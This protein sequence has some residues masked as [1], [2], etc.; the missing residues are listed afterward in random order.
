MKHAFTRDN[1]LPK[2][3]G[4]FN[5]M[6][7]RAFVR[8]AMGAMVLGHLVGHGESDRHLSDRPNFLWMTCEDMSPLFAA[9]SL[10]I[11]TQ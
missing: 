11:T 4:V 6:K 9:I 10:S 8:S 7:R 3:E 1:R 2:A 5:A